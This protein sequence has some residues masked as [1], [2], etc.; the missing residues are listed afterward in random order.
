MGAGP[1]DA[2]SKHEVNPLGELL[3]FLRSQS[4]DAK[5]I[6]VLTFDDFV[7]YMKNLNALYAI[8]CFYINYFY[9]ACVLR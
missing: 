8:I 9:F 7:M 3:S 1:S 4:L 2:V 5:R 6:A